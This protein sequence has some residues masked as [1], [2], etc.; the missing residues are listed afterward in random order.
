MPVRVTEV[1]Q[2][3]IKQSEIRSVLRGLVRLMACTGEEKKVECIEILYALV[4]G[5]HLRT[6]YRQIAAL[7]GVLIVDE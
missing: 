7:M 3:Q 6:R 5:V 2:E 4:K 1:L